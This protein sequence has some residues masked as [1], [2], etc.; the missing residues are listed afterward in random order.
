MAAPLAARAERGPIDRGHPQNRAQGADPAMSFPTTRVSKITGDF[1]TPIRVVCLH[2]D[3]RVLLIHPHALPCF[4][5]FDGERIVLVE[6]RP[7]G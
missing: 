2:P 5:E 3:E 6:L 4:A 1:E 7:H